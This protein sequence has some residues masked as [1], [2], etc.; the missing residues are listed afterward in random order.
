MEQQATIIGTC[1]VLL[2]NMITEAWSEGLHW[3]S[4]IDRQGWL[5]VFCVA[6]AIGTFWLRGFGSRSK[7]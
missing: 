4:H 7:Y 5:I 2:G 3:V 1:G 6:L